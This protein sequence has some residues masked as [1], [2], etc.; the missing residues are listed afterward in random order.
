MTREQ[1][2]TQAR[3]LRRSGLEYLAVQAENLF[4]LRTEYV[5]SPP[6]APN[7]YVD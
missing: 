7:D 6:I 2:L 1:Y 3:S 4:M 5:E